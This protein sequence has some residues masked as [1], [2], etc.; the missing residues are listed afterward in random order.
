MALDSASKRSSAVNVGSPW[1]AR[2]PFPDGTI[3][4]GDRQ[5]VAFMYSGILAGAAV[6]IE[7]FLG[8][9]EYTMPRSRLEYTI[10]R[11]ADYTMES[12]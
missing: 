11:S 2:L 5:A 7:D 3:D 9:L 12:P 4:Q 10:P 8:R 1:R 6:A